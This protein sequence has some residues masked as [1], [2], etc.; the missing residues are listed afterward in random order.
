MRLNGEVFGYWGYGSIFTT[1]GSTLTIYG[2]TMT[3]YGS[4]SLFVIVHMLK[5]CYN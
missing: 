2:S 3:I 4:Q 5:M 1:Y